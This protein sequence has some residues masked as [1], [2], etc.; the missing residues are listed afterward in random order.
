VDD[1]KTWKNKHHIYYWTNKVYLKTIITT[2]QN[3]GD[4]TKNS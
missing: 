2:R 1:A 3:N 4:I